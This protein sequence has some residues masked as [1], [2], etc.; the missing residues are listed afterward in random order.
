[1]RNL[2]PMMFADVGA[3][4]CP[5]L[6]ATD[7]QGSGEGDDGGWGLVG[8]KPAPEDLLELFRRGCR[9]GF[10]VLSL[11][12]SMQRLKRPDKALQARVPFT[13]VPLSMVS[14]PDCWVELA[15]G[16]WKFS[17]HITLGE[18]RASLKI[19]NLL[20]LSGLRR[21]RVLSLMDNLAWAGAAAKGRSPAPSMNYLLRRRCALCISAQL[22]LY[23]PWTDTTHQPGDS[24]SRLKDA[25]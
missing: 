7:A 19:L 11:D 22:S 8:S 23:L 5:Y 18:A 20:A 1:M 9:P 21:H 25:S 16:R 3:K 2:L 17:D 13:K 15:H 6:F 10:T 12:G 24:L 4:L 14:S